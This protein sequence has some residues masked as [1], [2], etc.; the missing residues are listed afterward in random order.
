[1]LPLSGAAR[2]VPWACL[3]IVMAIVVAMTARGVRWAV[4]VLIVFV[5]LDQGL[6]GY[7]YAYRWGPIARIDAL[8]A[9]APVPAAARRGDL[10]APLAEGGPGNLAVL[11]G[12]RLTTGYTGLTTT[13][14]LDPSDPI[15]ER[16][17]GVAWRATTHGWVSVPDAMPRARLV[18]IARQSRTM[19]A[20]LMGTTDLLGDLPGADIARV[21][22]VDRPIDG[23]SGVAGT[24][25][26]AADRSGFIAVETD[27]PGRQLLALTERFHPGWRVAIDGRAAHS[28]PVY[29]DFLGCVVDSGRHRLTFTF[30][31]DSA[32][33]G[34]QV[35]LVGV[36]L[37][38]VGSALLW[39][40]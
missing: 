2:S 12:V 32:R 15:T 14:V 23:L 33:R 34:L 21:A 36:T 6:W 7:S 22:L 28:V 37:T 3:V 39:R 38:L 18:S 9:D 26:V 40:A 5:A 10:I 20:D 24:V 8:A 13:S 16:L 35:T 31:P 27:A 1:M 29:G 25:H 4:P 17:A 19:K 11:R 30:A